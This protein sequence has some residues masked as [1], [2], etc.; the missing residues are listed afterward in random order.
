MNIKTNAALLAATLTALTALPAQAQQVVTASVNARAGLA[1]LTAI[2][3][4]D[5]NFG[6]WR[7]PSRTT[8][9]STV[10]TLTVSANNASGTTT[11]TVTGNNTN[12]AV[13]SGYNAS[14]AATCAVT[15]ATTV[16]ATLPTTITN[17]VGLAFIS[18][19]HENLATPSVL[20][21]MVATL[22]LGGTGVVIDSAGSG[23]FRVVGV[24]TVPQAVTTTNYGGYKTSTSATVSMTDQVASTPT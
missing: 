9:G 18:S 16:S 23:S 1:P 22:T 21:A 12:V 5:V 7:M 14:L 2:S 3:C 10:I 6:V 11:A 15:G 8:G 20:S 13:A 19:N 4:D 17:N 24:L